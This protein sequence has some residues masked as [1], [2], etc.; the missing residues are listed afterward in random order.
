M[1][2][3]L[4]NSFFADSFIDSDDY[5]NP[6]REN[7]RT[8]SMLF[9]NPEYTATLYIGHINSVVSRDKGWL[10]EDKTEVG[11]IKIVTYIPDAVPST[12]D[13][14]GINLLFNIIL[15]AEHTDTVTYIKYSKIQD[16]LANLGGVINFC[17]LT[18]V[19]LFNITNYFDMSFELYCY[20]YLNSKNFTIKS[21]PDQSNLLTN[22]N[23][24]NTNRSNL[25]TQNTINTIKPSNTQ[26]FN[27]PVINRGDKF[28]LKTGFCK[29]MCSR[30][31]GNM[32]D[33]N[34]MNIIHC[35]I[36]KEL[37]VSGYLRLKED[38]YLLKSILFNPEETLIFNQ[39]TDFRDVQR[40]FKENNENE[41]SDVYIDYLKASYYP[42]K[43]DKKQNYSVLL[44]MIRKLRVRFQML[45][46]RQLNTSPI[47]MNY[48]KENTYFK[49]SVEKD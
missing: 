5:Q 31:T 11:N 7:I 6:N 24:N 32:R 49:Q 39:I 16:V 34:K 9:Q 4:I 29:Y 13:S 28:T 15:Y 46:E 36:R 3:L 42:R 27:Q 41:V 1:N 37:E 33:F 21:N 47:K 48:I 40:I 19:V 2:N 44:E 12:I 30:I 18:W 45:G 17:K 23:M 43:L 20:S 8:D 38:I 26:T 22:N 25:K 35:K 14:L 10:L